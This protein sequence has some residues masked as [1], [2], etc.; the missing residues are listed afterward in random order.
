[1][2]PMKNEIEQNLNDFK[3]KLMALNAEF[4]AKTGFAVNS[5]E[6]AL[7]SVRNDDEP[8]IGFVKKIKLW[9]DHINLEFSAENSQ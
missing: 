7:Y 6:F 8:R 1:M 5:V 4:V 3:E 2:G 9:S